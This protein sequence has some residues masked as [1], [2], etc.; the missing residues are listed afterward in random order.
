MPGKKS[1]RRIACQ[2]VD[3]NR[4]LS[5][6]GNDSIESESKGV[7]C[8]K[9]ESVALQKSKKLPPAL[10]AGQFG[11]EFIGLDCV[12]SV[13]DVGPGEVDT[14]NTIQPDKLDTKLTGV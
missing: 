8:L 11:V 14:A 1:Q 6:Q 13:E 7:D 3:C 12:C 4:G 2:W 10:Y 5:Q 9:P